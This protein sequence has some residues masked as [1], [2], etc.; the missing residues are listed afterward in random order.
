MQVSEV[1]IISEAEF[2]AMTAAQQSPQ[3]AAEVSLPQA[4]PDAPEVQEVVPEPEPEAA[5][6][7]D[8]PSSDTDACGRRCSRRAGTARACTGG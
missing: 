7:V 8:T 4:E 3:L 2:A 1:A 5:A 6:R